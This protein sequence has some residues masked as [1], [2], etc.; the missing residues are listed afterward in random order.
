[1]FLT[2]ARLKGN[3]SPALAGLLSRRDFRKTATPLLSVQETPS[4]SFA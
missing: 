4:A 1:M 2:T 3:P